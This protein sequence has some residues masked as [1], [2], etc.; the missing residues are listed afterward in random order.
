LAQGLNIVEFNYDFD[1][2]DRE[3]LLNKYIDQEVHIKD[4]KS[5]KWKTCRLL[6]AEGRGHC[7]LE[8]RITKEI[9]FEEIRATD[10]IYRL[11][12]RRWRI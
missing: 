1:L 8:D 12:C 4:R 11:D 7:V 6:S 10:A 5:G 9:Y 3:K 2:V